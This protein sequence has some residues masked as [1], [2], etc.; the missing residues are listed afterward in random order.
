VR[1]RFEPV[2]RSS[3]RTRRSSAFSLVELVV[4]IAILGVLSSI[5]LP[6]LQR[7]VWRAKRNEAF[8]NLNGIFKSQKAYYAANGR[9][10]STFQDIGFE[11]SGGRELD[12]NTIQ[13][14]YYTYTLETFAVDG[15]ANANYSAVATGDIDPTDAM[16][17]IVMIESG[18]VIVE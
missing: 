10:G 5:A 6:S 2:V 1:H 17:D 15:V 14:R 4:V 8:I 18:A 16:L 3:L 7:Y 12:P 9:Y 11:I 13:S